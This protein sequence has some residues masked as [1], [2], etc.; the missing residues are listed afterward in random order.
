MVESVELREGITPAV[1]LGGWLDL[2][3]SL[4]AM[5]FIAFSLGV[6]RSRK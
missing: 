6:G 3:N 2:I 1:A 4:M 5:S